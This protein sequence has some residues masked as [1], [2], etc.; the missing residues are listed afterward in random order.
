MPILPYAGRLPVLGPRVFLAP[1]AQVTGDV[2]LGEDVSFWYHT[3][4][5]GDVNWIRVGPRTNIQDGAILHVSYGTYP[6]R[7]GADVVVGHQAVLHGC[8]VEDGALILPRLIR[9][10]EEQEAAR[11]LQ[12]ELG[13]GGATLQREALLERLRKGL[14]SE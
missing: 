11:R 10:L 8:T 2:E 14:S 1:D 6:L 12:A 7:I 5:R 13:D 9:A 4:A 3:A